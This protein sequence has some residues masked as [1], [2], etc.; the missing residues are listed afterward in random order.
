MFKILD[1]SFDICEGDLDIS[2][3][4][5]E[6]VV[7][8]MVLFLD[9]NSEFRIY[10]GLESDGPPFGISG[11][12]YDTTDYEVK[13]LPENARRKLSVYRGFIWA[14]TDQFDIAQSYA[15][16]NKLYADTASDGSTYGQLTTAV[17]THN[18]TV[19]GTVVR[20]DPQRNLLECN[21][22]I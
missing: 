22:Q 19:L 18:Q 1:A 6:D 13:N 12:D 15:P 14:E 9:Q 17:P 3:E 4:E 5:D 8:G 20:Y 11:D 10:K 21:L 2:E 16:G 7:A